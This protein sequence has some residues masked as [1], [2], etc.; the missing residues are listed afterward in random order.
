MTILR[1]YI[2]VLL[3]LGSLAGGAQVRPDQFP[4]KTTHTGTDFE[5]YSQYGGVNEKTTPFYLKYY[6]APNVDSAWQAF[7]LTD[8]IGI[9]DSLRMMFL[10]DN[11]G[12]V[13]YVD[14]DGDALLLKDTAQ[15]VGNV[16]ALA[17]LADTSTV[18]TPVEGDIAVVGSDTLLFYEAYWL[19]FAGG[20]GG[21]YSGSG[22]VPASTW[23]EQLGSLIFDIDSLG[24]FTVGDLDEKSTG[25]IISVS[26]GSGNNGAINIR[27]GSGAGYT[28]ATVQVNNNEMPGTTPSGEG[29]PTGD[30]FWIVSEGG[31]RK[32]KDSTGWI[33]IDS[34]LNGYTTGSGTSGT[35]PIWTGANALGSSSLTQSGGNVVGTSFT[36]AFGLAV[37]TDAQRPVGANGQVRYN[38][39]GGGVEA[40]NG[41]LAAYTYL[42]WS[43]V[44][45]FTSGS[46]LFADA[47]GR[48]AQDNSNFSYASDKL[49]LGTTSLLDIRPVSGASNTAVS[50]GTVDTQVGNTFVVIGWGAESDNSSAVAVGPNTRANQSGTAIGNSADA[51]SFATS[52]G[53]SSVAS[54]TNSVAV[55]P[56]TA[57]VSG[58][59]A[60]G[61]GASATTQASCLAIGN[62]A[63]VSNYGTAIGRN[64]TVDHAGSIAIGNGSRS[65]APNQFVAGSDVGPGSSGEH[66]EITDVY[67]GSG[68]QRGDK[69]SATNAGSGVS[70]TIHGSGAAGTNNNGGNITVAGGKGTGAGTPGDVIFS[71]SDAGAAGSTLQTLTQRVW[72][73]G[74]TGQLS[75]GTA[76]PNA[77][78][79]VQ[80]ESTT[81]GFLPPRM[82]T[83][84]RD[85]IG[86]PAAGLVIFN[87]TTT[88]LECYDGSTWQ[89]AW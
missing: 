59:I 34:L 69:G 46:V 81:Q 58:G 28:T 38:T 84:Q 52:I 86:S 36:G 65:T 71:T 62:N 12:R 2:S 74:E 51:G 49:Y 35:L 50:I 56:A 3:L 39:T 6:Y 30:Y 75:V 16:Y 20:A 54:G 44:A 14:A 43:S 32:G 80:V 48:I 66:Y 40:W 73:K 33:H 13:F 21:I 9:A 15:A 10:K 26:N 82:T 18:A 83:A 25:A 64:T 17:T 11:R 41:G 19:M 29:L 78:A 42:P 23:V 31:S 1:I 45:S 8:S 70:Y 7:T 67:F 72:V 24:S 57:S 55:G 61:E 22:T 53:Q 4:L 79:L 60:I 88:K 68:V 76:I 89:A 77:S 37:G 63:D 87:T 47:S 27:S 85:A 5:I